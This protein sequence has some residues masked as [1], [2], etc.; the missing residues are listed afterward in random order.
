MNGAQGKLPFELVK[1]EVLVRKEAET[2]PRFG[3][4]PEK[5]G[6]EDLLKYGVVNIDK[7]KGP[8]S[9]QVA[10]YVKQILGLK[11]TGHSGTLDPKVTGS[12]VVAL[13]NATKVAQA[14]LTAGK[15]YIAV[16]HLHKDVEE[17]DIHEA[18]AAFVGKI[19]QL[20]PIK[21][22]VKRRERYRR[23]YY[24]DIIEIDGKDVLFRVGTEAG[25]YIRKLT[26]DIG[27][28]LGTGAHMAE[29]RR[30]K[31]GPFDESTL[32]TFQNLQDAFWVYKNKKDDKEL[33]K[34]IQPMENAVRH[35]PK[36]WVLD[37][38][39]NSLCHGATLHV[40]GIAKAES[41]IEKENIVAVMTLKD[42]LIALSAAKMSSREMITNK[43]GIAAKSE[44]VFMEPGVYPRIE[45]V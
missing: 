32:V 8:T 19:K 34:L 4:A 37:T 14:L 3:S 22:S 20:P 40:P 24:L 29:L 43:K 2:S 11:K 5:R 16:M 13:A 26:H 35:I 25:T 15:E 9:H 41:G 31:V 23:V 33:R 30:T 42:E 44:R 21:S 12:L 39:V 6:T 45:R 17:Y 36:I 18:C 10:A 28:K 38:T 27:Q 7:P 1:R